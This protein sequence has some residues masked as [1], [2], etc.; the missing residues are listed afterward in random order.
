[1]GLP[2]LR[3]ELEPVEVP[4]PTLPRRSFTTRL[5]PGEK[6]LLA[7]GLGVL[8]AAYQGSMSFLEHLDELRKRLIVSMVALMVGIL[9]AFAFVSQIFDFMMRPLQKTLPAGGTLIYT[10]PTE[11][12]FLYVKMASLAGVFIAAPIILWQVWLFVAPGLYTREK[13]LAIPFVVFSTLFFVSGGLFSHFV[14]FQWAWRFFGSF[15]SETVAFMPRIAPIF[16]FYT[17]MLLGFGLMFQM[18]ILAFFLA[19][20]GVITARFLVRQFK[21]AVLL[22]FIVAAVLTPSPDPVNQLMMAGPMLALYGLSILIAW[23]FGTA[24]EDQ[25]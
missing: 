3:V 17:Q 7:F 14:A 19:R 18:P 6:R 2:L 9:V 10:E 1:M 5:S 15:G 21:Y 24:T 20:M 12:F 16:S 22:V 23:I 4:A 11:A 8:A 13:K 25:N